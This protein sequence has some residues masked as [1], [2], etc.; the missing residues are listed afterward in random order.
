MEDLNID[1]TIDN[2][3]LVDKAP[4]DL[5]KLSKEIIEKKNEY[6]KV[7]NKASDLWKEIQNLEENLHSR[8][9]DANIESF[10]TEEALISRKYQ[11]WAK[12]TDM[13]KAQKFFLEEGV[14]DEMLQTIARKGRLN[15]MVRKLIKGG[16]AVPDGIDYSVK[17]TIGI[18]RNG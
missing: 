7:K 10:R 16:F 1:L 8:M 2:E 4:I 6:N 18:R 12:V 5:S 14:A 17:P 13:D 9:E 3:D 15:E 11:Y